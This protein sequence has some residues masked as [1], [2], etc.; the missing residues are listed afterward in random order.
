[1]QNCNDIAGSQA[2][3]TTVETASRKESRDHVIAVLECKY[4]D[5][6]MCFHCGIPLLPTE[7]DTWCCGKGGRMHPSWDPPPPDLMKLISCPAWGHISRIVNSLFTMTVMHSKDRGLW[8]HLGSLAPAMRVQGHIYARLMRNTDHFWFVSDAAYGQG[9]KDLSAQQKNM[10]H[11]FHRIL[12]RESKM[13]T[14][15]GDLS[16]LPLMSE[17]RE[18]QIIVSASETFLS[19]HGV[20]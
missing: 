8:Y 20:S 16:N 15:S 18:G 17:V 12:L 13:F 7:H 10:V 19:L 4:V 14:V 1:M 5:V 2:F 11:I 9:Y 3:R 6:R